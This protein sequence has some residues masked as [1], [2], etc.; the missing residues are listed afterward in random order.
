MS[1]G[2]TQE[3]YQ[4]YKNEMEQGK[5][6]RQRIRWG[7]VLDSI[8][9]S[10]MRHLKRLARK[11]IP[12]EVRKQAWYEL[13][14]ARSLHQ[15]YPKFYQEFCGRLRAP[16]MFELEVGQVFVSNQ[17]FGSLQ[18]PSAL[19]STRTISARLAM[20]RILL[21]L[22]RRKLLTVLPPAL[23]LLC[24]TLLIVTKDEVVSFWIMVAFLTEPK[25]R[26]KETDAVDFLTAGTRDCTV[27]AQ[28]TLA[29]LAKK[30][31][32][33]HEH[34]QSRNIDLI[35]IFGSWLSSL[36]IELLPFDTLMRV[37]DAYFVEG[38][39][40]LLRVSLA[41]LKLNKE[42]LL[43]INDPF[44]LA[45]TLKAL[46]RRH[47]DQAELMSVAFEG[48]GSMSCD[49]IHKIRVK[50]ENKW[51]AV[52]RD[53]AKMYESIKGIRLDDPDDDCWYQEEQILPSETVDPSPVSTKTTP[54][55]HYH[56]LSFTSPVP[57]K[58]ASVEMQP[59]LAASPPRGPRRSV[60][61]VQSVALAPL[62]E[63]IPPA[64]AIK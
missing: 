23:S 19:D 8:E 50:C 9:T 52:P 41:L 48:I 5:I 45:E 64:A 34:L 16:R 51:L 20:A 58:L 6:S 12:L 46:P 25:L 28:V 44:E 10:S 7:L 62:I 63:E 11:G 54:L 55:N 53:H 3:A 27:E 40:I 36:F 18:V 4:S 37:F 49:D 15:R 31:R 60:C 56:S 21:V 1:A 42:R 22:S 30:Q 33:L 17:Q 26:P 39:K 2:I 14:G 24:A 47:L 29:L 13:S 38:E 59:I 61:Q 57:I 35:S 32:R 43:A